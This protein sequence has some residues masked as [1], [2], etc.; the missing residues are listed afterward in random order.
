MSRVVVFLVSLTVSVWGRTRSA[1]QGKGVANRRR[2][3]TSPTTA[4]AA[5]IGMGG[6]MATMLLM[7]AA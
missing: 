4:L 5:H 2:P 6:T 7:M 3:G 1:G